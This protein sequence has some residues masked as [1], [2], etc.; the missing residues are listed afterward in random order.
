MA[1]EVTRE[2]V[3]GLSTAEHHLLNAELLSADIRRVCRAYLALEE[4]CRK[5]ETALQEL[6]R[7]LLDGGDGSAHAAESVLVERWAEIVSAALRDLDEPGE[8]K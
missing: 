7:Q 1:D 5:R 6:D 3:K 8:E 2:W 4:R